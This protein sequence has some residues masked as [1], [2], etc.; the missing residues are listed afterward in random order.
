[1]HTSQRDKRKRTAPTLSTK[2]SD[3]YCS[4]SNWETAMLDH[5]GRLA[6]FFFKSVVD[7]TVSNQVEE[8][9]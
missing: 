2:A 9:V 3:V 1:M 5:Q 8:G 6:G 4:E 7:V